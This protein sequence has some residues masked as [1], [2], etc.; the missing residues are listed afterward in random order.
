M[1]SRDESPRWGAILLSPFLLFA[2]VWLVATAVREARP[3]IA[4]VD[5]FASCPRRT[6]DEGVG[7]AARWV[8]ELR[9]PEGRVTPSGRPAAAYRAKLYS[10]TKGERMVEQVKTDTKGRKTTRMVRETVWEH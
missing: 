6:V 7:V 9:G 1:P 10:S 4:L 2:G 3:G 8:G 5:W